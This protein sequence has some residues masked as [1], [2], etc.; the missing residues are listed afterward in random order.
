LQ[1]GSLNDLSS[2]ISCRWAHACA[3]RRGQD[4]GP[5][6]QYEMRVRSE[7]DSGGLLASSQYVAA[8]EPIVQRHFSFR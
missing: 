6:G 1:G 5:A 3:C 7:V 2:E 4:E 8:I